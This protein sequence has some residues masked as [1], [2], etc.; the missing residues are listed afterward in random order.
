[1][2]FFHIVSVQNKITA[3]TCPWFLCRVSPAILQINPSAIVS[4]TSYKSSQK[5]PKEFIWG[6]A[7]TILFNYLQK[8]TERQNFGHSM[9]TFCDFWHFLANSRTIPVKISCKD[10]FCF[11]GKIFRNQYQYSLATSIYSS[12]RET[13]LKRI[14]SL[15]EYN[16]ASLPI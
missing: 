13:V 1:M 6:F 7:W 3:N 8:V 10:T 4:H 12:R 5:P 11:S 15:Q 9:L 16:L 14:S 2:R